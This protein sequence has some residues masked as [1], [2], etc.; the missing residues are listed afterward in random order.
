MKQ[1]VHSSDSQ[2]QDQ[3]EA[4]PCKDTAAAQA[5]FSVVQKQ[6]LQ[7]LGNSSEALTSRQLAAAISCSNGELG[8]ALDQLVSRGFV[9]RLN[10]IIPSYSNRYPGVRVYGE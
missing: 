3:S 5:E 1:P 8:R 4:S 7:C 10:T 6:V 2:R 9:S